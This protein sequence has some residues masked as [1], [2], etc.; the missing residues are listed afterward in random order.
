VEISRNTIA[1]ARRIK[2]YYYEP[3]KPDL[4]LTHRMLSTGDAIHL[5]TAIIY[6]VDELHTRDGN[7]SK[8]N[9]PLLGLAE[10]SANGKIAGQYP[11]KIVSP[12]DQQPDLLDALQ[13]SNV[14]R[15]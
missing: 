2:D 11:L 10:S 13:P 3:A 1:L 14:T 4:G 7:R 15:Q 12:E 6:K 8:G 9:V 5:A